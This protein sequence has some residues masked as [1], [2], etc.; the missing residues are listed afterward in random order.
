E[1]GG[2]NLVAGTSDTS[3]STF[4][5]ILDE[6]DNRVTPE[7]QIEVI[8]NK[9]KKSLSSISEANI[10]VMAMPSIPGISAVGGFEY[11]L[12]N[13][14]NA[15]LGEFETVAKE[16]IAAANKDER[17]M[18]AY[19]SF[20]SN[21]P[22]YFLDIDR[23]KIY[24]LNV[25]ISDV[26]TV[27]Q[28]YLGSMY[29]NDFNKFGKIYRV[30]LQAEQ[31]FRSEKNDIG[32]FYVKN[33]EGE[34]VPLSTFVEIK[35]TSGAAVINHFNSYQ[36]IS[37]NGLHNLKDGYSSTDAIMAMEELSSKILSKDYGYEWAGMA[38]QEKEAG[39]AAMIIF[40]LSFTFVFL[41]LSAQYESW[42]MPLMIMIPIPVVFMGALGANMLAGLMNNTY[43][44]IGLVLLIGM[45]SKNA[46]LIIEFA[47][48]LRD[49]GMSIVESAIS[50]AT[51]R[52]R[53]ILMTIFS[54]LLGILPLVIAAGP[55]AA[56]RQSLG[57]A[58]F[59][60]MIVST[61]LTLFFTPLLFVLLQRLRERN[62]KPKEVINETK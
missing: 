48:E 5:V 62:N 28:S 52:L 15:S 37:I 16:I 29:V 26:F 11:K 19:T 17:I 50:A 44:Q 18:T 9:L 4:F 35:K 20:N 43:T 56:A 3:T 53:A 45:S 54:F 14:Q 7:L 31:E 27:L 34:M 47:K 61:V 12:K 41:F 39:S 24:K 21:Y 59:G 38:L 23:E 6:W 33:K 22:Q 10:M 55:G 1:I 46:I 58:V 57:T 25:D 40:L 2:F 30:F 49:E 13:L 51:L 42:I 36:S 8:K 60:G 32:K